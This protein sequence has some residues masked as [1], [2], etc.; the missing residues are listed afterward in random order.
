MSSKN[1]LPWNSSSVRE[2]AVRNRVG[3]A[4]EGSGIEAEVGWRF[5]RF[6]AKLIP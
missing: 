3:R 4:G 6:G 2:T 1:R 5:A